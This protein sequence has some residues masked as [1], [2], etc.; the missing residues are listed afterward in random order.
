MVFLRVLSIFLK[1]IIKALRRIVKNRFLVR[2]LGLFKKKLEPFDSIHE[3][4]P[5]FDKLDDKFLP[6][7]IEA[8]LLRL[9]CKEIVNQSKSTNPL[10][11]KAVLA[12]DDTPLVTVYPGAQNC[13][14]YEQVQDSRLNDPKK[15]IRKLEL[16]SNEYLKVSR[17]G[18]DL[19]IHRL[20][21][22]QPEFRLNND[23]WIAYNG[24]DAA[25]KI[26]Q[27]RKRRR[28]PY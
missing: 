4:Y 17:N 20:F 12:M 14:I 15:I 23:D 19:L 3:E 1:L 21:P 6:K 13:Y 5:F 7:D 18:L 16:V 8:F 22:N 26:L 25:H 2:K 11:W 28:I 27:S 9:T 24:L 10:F